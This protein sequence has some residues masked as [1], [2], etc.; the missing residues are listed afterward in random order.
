MREETEPPPDI[1]PC[2]L[3]FHKRD[4]VSAA[5]KTLPLPTVVKVTNLE[6]GKSLNL[7]VDDRGPYIDNR[8]IDL[9]IGAAKFLGV[10]ERGTA[11]VRVQSIPWMVPLLTLDLLTVALPSLHHDIDQLCS[12]KISQKR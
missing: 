7:V 8:I 12:W 2:T 11:K 3:I 10:Y 4:C 9:S 5:H 1:F 6:N